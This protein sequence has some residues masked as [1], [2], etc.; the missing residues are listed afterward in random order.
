M[1]EEEVNTALR[2]RAMGFSCAMADD[3]VVYHWGSLSSGGRFNEF[4]AY[5]G[6]RNS[7]FTQ[8]KNLP[9]GFFL[10][11]GGWM[12]L[13]QCGVIG[14]Y[15]VKGKFRLVWRIYRDFLAGLPTMLA[16][17]RRFRTALG[18]PQLAL[19]MSRKFYASGYVLDTLRNLFR[20]NI[21]PARW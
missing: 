6:L 11:Y 13:M 2:A 10:R 7:L 14:K 16:K 18:G 4:I 15:L 1:K 21:P 5:H 3:A 17:R 9:A 20:R 19:P 12:V 8:V